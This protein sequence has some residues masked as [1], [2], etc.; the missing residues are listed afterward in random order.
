MDWTDF[1]TDFQESASYWHCSSVISRLTVEMQSNETACS[2]KKKKR[3][4]QDFVGIRAR[5]ERVTRSLASKRQ[6]RKMRI[7]WT[8][9]WALWLQVAECKDTQWERARVYTRN[10]SRH[11]GC[12]WGTELGL[13]V[14]SGQYEI[15]V[16]ITK[17]NVVRHAKLLKHAGCEW[18]QVNRGL[19]GR[20]P[21]DSGNRKGKSSHWARFEMSRACSVRG[22]RCCSIDDPQFH[23]I[24]IYDT[25]ARPLITPSEYNWYVNWAPPKYVDL[26][27][28]DLLSD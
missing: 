10:R 14:Q 5:G 7:K 2:I 12:E 17:S 27:P 26:L 21:P 18:R 9:K 16:P 19:S 25:H 4:N 8:N 6:R 24:K 28:I 11:C 13:A 1:W 23:T 3:K 22:A 20:L 15:N